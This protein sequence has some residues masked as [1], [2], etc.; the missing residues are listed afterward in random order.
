MIFTGQAGTVN[1][2]LGANNGNNALENHVIAILSNLRQHNISNVQ[3][4]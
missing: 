4:V 3:C 2:Q 1:D